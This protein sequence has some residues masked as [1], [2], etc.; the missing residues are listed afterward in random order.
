MTW[1]ELARNPADMNTHS[2]PERL[3]FSVER[4]AEALDL[5]RRTV[6]ALIRRGDLR[7]IR[8]GG[9]RLIRRSDLL[10]YLESDH[11]QITG[12]GLGRGR[13]PAPDAPECE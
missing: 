10:R 6:E 9:R 7:S 13:R 2:E 12:T 3:A 11:P 1:R 8:V 4:A 5:R